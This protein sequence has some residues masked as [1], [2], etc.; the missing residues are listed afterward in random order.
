MNHMTVKFSKKKK[1]VFCLDSEGL[2]RFDHL[3][4]IHTQ[5]AI[6]LKKANV[7]FH[8]PYSTN[9]FIPMSYQFRHMNKYYQFKLCGT[10]D[11]IKYQIRYTQMCCIWN[12]IRNRK[13]KM[14]RNSNTLLEIDLDFMSNI[15]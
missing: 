3:L 5:T 1:K 4:K 13:A 6:H 10:N 11:L 14:T 7:F 15:H 12:C 8:L 2:N 9:H